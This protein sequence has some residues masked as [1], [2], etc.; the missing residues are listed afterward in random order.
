LITRGGVRS[1]RPRAGL[2]VA[3]VALIGYIVGNGGVF[4]YVGSYISTE[5][6]KT[7]GTGLTLV[8]A[9]PSAGALASD[10]APFVTASN[11]F[12]SPLAGVVTWLFLTSVTGSYLGANTQL[13]RIVFSG[14]REGLWN[15]RLAL[16]HPRFRT[17]WVAVLACVVPGV[18]VGIVVAL[19]T[20]VATATSFVPTLGILGITTMFVAANAALVVHWVRERAR[21]VRRSV[22]GCVVVPL[23]GIVT[24]AVPYWSDFQPGQPA[25]FSYLPWYFLGLLAIGVLYVLYLQRRKPMMVARAGSIIMGE[26]APV[27]RAQVLAP[28]E[29]R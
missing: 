27:E 17:P 10:P 22:L 7:D 5:V 28:D 19:T 3:V 16:V 14:A 15:R 25:P 29:P 2:G 12:I 1:V 26:A 21:G 11:W 4:V 6:F 24:L 13:A 9:F 18:V 8:M 23:V 20:S